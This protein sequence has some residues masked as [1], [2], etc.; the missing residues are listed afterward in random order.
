M[1]VFIKTVNNEQH[2][3]E[4][5]PE[6]VVLVNHF[7]EL[8]QQKT[9]V[10]IDRQ[11]LIYRGKVLQDNSDL[12]IYKLEDQSV[13][14]LVVRP[15]NFRELQQ[16]AASSSSTTS[17]APEL[18][19]AA[20]W[21]SLRIPAGLSTIGAPGITRV[22]QRT[23]SS[24]G[25]LFGN[26]NMNSI[27]PTNTNVPVIN[28]S[29]NGSA[30]V[31]PENSEALPNIEHIRQSLLTLNTLLSTMNPTTT[32][33][34]PRQIDENQAG[35]RRFYTGQWL[36]VKD[37]VNQWLEATILQVDQEGNRIFVHYNGWPARWDEWISTNSPRIAPFRSRT[38]HSALNVN[39]SP[40]P[41]II[42]NHA[43]STGPNDIRAIIPEFA[44]VVSIMNNMMQE[45]SE[46]SIEVREILTIFLTL[47]S[48]YMYNYLSFK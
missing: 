10:E 38:N 16:Q 41:N 47:P 30:A 44:R 24:S 31:T 11:R 20:S 22:D 43:P 39:L 12:Q 4:Y 32:E 26:N 40:N 6:V 29:S 28:P 42:V 21:Q 34:M 36:D 5:D 23:A 37:T 15:V 17:A 27:T 33:S 35:F 3:I 8:V 1:K 45:I 13:I 19:S 46:A 48:F 18:T 2:E 7:K 25:S 9:A 14:H